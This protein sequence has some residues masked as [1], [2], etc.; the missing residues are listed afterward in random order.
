M[1]PASGK[2]TANKAGAEYITVSLTLGNDAIT[3]KYP[4]LCRGRD[5]YFCV[6]PYDEISEAQFDERAR[7]ITIS[8]LCNMIVKDRY[9]VSDQFFIPMNKNMARNLLFELG[10][11]CAK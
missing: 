2:L 9:E 10:E 8:G 3:L 6:I 5:D 11:I 4:V 7:G 1:D